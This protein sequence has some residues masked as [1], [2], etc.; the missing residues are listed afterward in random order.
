MVNKTDCD[1]SI[2]RHNDLLQRD[3]VSS[4]NEKNIFNFNKKNY[5]ISDIYASLS[6]SNNK[7]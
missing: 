2:L 5:L 1:E 4:R 7:Y 3:S 6:R